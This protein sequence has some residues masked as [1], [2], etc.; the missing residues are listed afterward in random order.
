M[1]KASSKSPVNQTERTTIDRRKFIGGVTAASVGLTVVPASVL[2]GARQ[3][4]PQ[5]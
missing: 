1:K 2:G 4:S 3:N 5:R